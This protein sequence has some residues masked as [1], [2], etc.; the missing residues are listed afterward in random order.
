MSLKKLRN[1]F[2]PKRSN[3]LQLRRQSYEFTQ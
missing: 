2:G 3:L 1:L